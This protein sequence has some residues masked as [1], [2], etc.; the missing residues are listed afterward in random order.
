MQSHKLIRIGNEPIFKRCGHYFWDVVMLII[1]PS[2]SHFNSF[3]SP[4]RK[5]K[6][7]SL[8]MLMMFS[9]CFSKKNVV[10]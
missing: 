4:T 2:I 10:H 3:V 9:F 6:S 1:M 7:F 8:N 5:A